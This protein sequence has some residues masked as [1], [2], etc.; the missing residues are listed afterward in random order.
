MGE[1]VKKK[2][3]GDVVGAVLM[4]I[5][6]MIF[7]ANNFGFLPWSVWGTLW[8]FWPVFLILSGVQMFLGESGWVR[9]IF[10][11][12][13]IM[14]LVGGLMYL[15]FSGMGA[16]KDYFQGFEGRGM[17]WRHEGIF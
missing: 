7:L 11:V 13:V 12:L 8:R 17:M 5:L 2:K 10:A 3:N 9:S 4:I 1:E 14:F 16:D 15:M 6:G